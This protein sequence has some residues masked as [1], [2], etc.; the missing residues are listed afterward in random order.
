M[1]LITVLIALVGA[2]AAQD[3][4]TAYVAVIGGAIVYFLHAIE[5]KLNRLL[6]EHGIAVWDDEVAKN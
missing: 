5:F 4:A 1:I 2:S 6:T 3:L